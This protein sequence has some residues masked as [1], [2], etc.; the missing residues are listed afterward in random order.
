MNN[1]YDEK[2]LRLYVISERFTNYPM[3]FSS[4][5]LD[6]YS[7]LFS[8]YRANFSPKRRIQLDRAVNFQVKN[9]IYGD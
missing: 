3:G 6:L 1:A 7:D 5:I 9:C 2:N 4:R 8:E